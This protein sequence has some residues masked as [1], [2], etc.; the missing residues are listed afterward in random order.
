[1]QVRILGWV[2]LGLIVGCLVVPCRS[3]S[4]TREAILTEETDH[5]ATRGV[6]VETDKDRYKTGELIEFCVSNHL[7]TP[8]TTRDQ[9]SFCSIIA[10][11]REVEGDDEW[12]EIRNCLS[13]APVAE[14][15]LDPGS[16]HTVKIKIDPAP[17]GALVSGRYRA[18]LFY[19]HGNRFSL[20]AENS[21]IARSEPF[22]ID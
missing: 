11:E 2:T 4:G 5:T 9:L 6:L 3:W 21:H 17:P 8:I 13:G 19:S 20:S 15:T 1:M 18:V 10:L 12:Q 16:S 7:D 22:L 14:V